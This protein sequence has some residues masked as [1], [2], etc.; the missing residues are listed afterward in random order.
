MRLI[1][2]DQGF[3]AGTLS[4]SRLLERKQVRKEST[5]LKTNYDLLDVFIS[6]NM[7]KFVLML[8][9]NILDFS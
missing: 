3:V 8:I 7:S 2:N 4:G 5:Q 1:P 6:D 9:K